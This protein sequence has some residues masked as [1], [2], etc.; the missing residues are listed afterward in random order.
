MAT[1]GERWAAVQLGKADGRPGSSGV[2]RALNELAQSRD[3]ELLDV[4]LKA[5]T[6]A[7]VEAQQTYEPRPADSKPTFRSSD[8]YSER[9]KRLHEIESLVDDYDEHW[10]WGFNRP[11]SRWAWADPDHLHRVAEA[12]NV[13]R[14]CLVLLP[15]ER[16]ASPDVSWHKKGIWYNEFVLRLR[17]VHLAEVES[18]AARLLEI[19]QKAPSKA[20]M[21]EPVVA[22]L[23]AVPEMMSSVKNFSLFL[24]RPSNALF[25]GR[26]GSAL[27]AAGACAMWHFGRHGFGL[28]ATPIGVLLALLAGS[29][30][31]GVGTWCAR[32]L[33]GS[34]ASKR[35]SLIE[36]WAN[37]IQSAR[38][39][40]E[41]HGIDAGLF[42]DPEEDGI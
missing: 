28:F 29:L 33:V 41:G 30:G 20:T 25:I 4:Y 19:S 12:A 31:A 5:R 37:H 9:T 42:R 2:A 21:S 36:R 6:N 14:R 39:A 13:L 26:W 18:T 1:P 10:Q 7:A 3:P 38:R 27:M 15:L 24:R 23:R 8:F 17:N 22:G 40:C 11:S 35:I 34:A 16:L 32:W